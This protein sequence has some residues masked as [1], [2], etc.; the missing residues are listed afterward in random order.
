[1]GGM[2][3][4]KRRLLFAATAPT[5]A[6]GYARIGHRLAHH[7]ADAYEVHYFAFQNYVNTAVLDRHVR[8]DIRLIDVHAL[9]GP[10]DMF[11]I[12]IVGNTLR[13]VRPDVLMVYNDVVVTCHIINEVLKLPRWQRPRR[14]VSYLD[15]VYNYQSR[16]LVEHVGKHADHVFVL[17]DHWVAH[18]S[19]WGVPAHKLQAFHHGFEFGEARVKTRDEA[20]RALG[21]PPSTFLVLNTNRNSY[22]KALDVT[23]GAFLTFFARAGRPDDAALVLNCRTDIAEGYDLLLV[24]RMWCQRLGLEYDDVSTRRIL[25]MRGLLPETAVVDMYVACDVGI[26]TCIGEGFGLCN[27][28]H[29]CF[30]APQVVSAVGGLKDVFRDFPGML[31]EPTAAFFLA[32]GVDSH[33][34]LAEV[35]DP[36]DFADRLA[37]QYERYTT[38][39]TTDP[40]L[41]RHMRRAH[42]WPSL[43]A[44]FDARLATCD[45]PPAY[46]INLATRPDRRARVEASLRSAGFHQDRVARIQPPLRRK[47]EE[48]CMAAHH[49]AI[50]AAWAAGHDL[51]VIVEDD[52]DMREG[53]ARALVEAARRLPDDW[54]VLQAHY[55]CPALLAHLGEEATEASRAMARRTAMRGYLM[56][57]ACYLINRRGMATFLEGTTGTPPDLALTADLSHPKARAEE[58]VF[59]RCVTYCALVPLVNTDETGGGD[60]PASTS[61]VENARLVAALM[62]GSESAEDDGPWRVRALPLDTHWFSSCLDAAAFVGDWTVDWWSRHAE[63]VRSLCTTQV[64]DVLEVGSFEGMSALWFLETFPAARVT[65]VDHWRGSAEHVSQDMRA[66]RARFFRNLSRHRGRVT[67][68]E[69]DSADALAS[70]ARASF[71]VTY[72]DGSHAASDVMDDLVLAWRALRV[73]G[74]LIADDYAWDGAS[75]DGPSHPRPAIDAFTRVYAPGLE[76]LHRG[77][78]VVVRKLS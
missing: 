41:A 45:C 29:A 75:P 43:L 17:A 10:A 47:P 78:Q 42:S 57:C 67:V 51:V 1:M 7:L 24:I 74:V 44:Q 36:E 34:G 9:C 14:I 16:E 55:S 39:K 76:V 8:P 22:R 13:R 5:Q 2:Q 18:L 27:M 72:V 68:M 77:Y 31:V 23:I 56:S 63:T 32:R 73:G 35:C 71:D 3:G 33:G 11:G 60:I 61:N 58:F 53:D 25:L 70:L 28:E 38:Q 52:V 19:Q 66:V 30:G 50:A 40:D 69:M 65:C 64:R 59:G 15:I 48:S 54:E 4:G 46:F 6:T 37:E 49:S 21:L 62:T 26:N 12:G 20:R